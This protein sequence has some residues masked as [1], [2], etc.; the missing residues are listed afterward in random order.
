MKSRMNL[1]FLGYFV[2]GLAWGNLNDND[3]SSPAVLEKEQ[4]VITKEYF[5]EEFDDEGK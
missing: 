4:P 3:D 2:I 1:I 5:R